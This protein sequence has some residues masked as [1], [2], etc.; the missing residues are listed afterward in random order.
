M[1]LAQDFQEHCPSKPAS[2]AFVRYRNSPVWCHG[3]A[4]G[5]FAHQRGVAFARGKEI[6][7][8]TSKA[9]KAEQSSIVFVFYTPICQQ[10]FFTTVCSATQRQRER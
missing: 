5:Q 9:T 1:Q 8:K 2:P 7:E 10:W 4:A 3:S 6:D